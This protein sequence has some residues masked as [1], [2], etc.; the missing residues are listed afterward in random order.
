[1]SAAI[2][3]LIFPTSAFA[4]TPA[5]D[6]TGEWSGF[7]QELNYQDDIYGNYRCN[8]TWKINAQVTQ[9]GNQL[10]IHYYGI[11]TKQDQSHQYYCAQISDH[12]FILTGT[13]DG[14]RITINDFYFPLAGWYASAG[15]K[16][17]GEEKWQDYND[18][19]VLLSGGTKLS[20][21]LS[22]TNFKVVPYDDPEPAPKPAPFDQDSQNQVGS[23][24]TN[25]GSATITTTDG[26][27]VN[28]NQLE[29]GQTIQTGT[30]TNVEILLIDE[31]VVINLKENT[32][33]G[34]YKIIFDPNEKDS[35][36][37][38]G[39]TEGFS[40]GTGLN[41]KH[42]GLIATG[43]ATGILLIITG[44]ATPGVILIGTVF[45]LVTGALVYATSD[46][47]SEKNQKVIFTPDAVLLPHGTKFTVTVENGQTKLDV[48]EGEVTVF[49][50][51]ENDPIQTVKAGNS[52]SIS[53]NDDPKPKE[54]VP[55][56]IKN[57]AKWW[58]EG[59]LDDADFVTV[60]QYMVKEKAIYIPDLP[61]QNIFD[62]SNY[63]PTLQFAKTTAKLW[64]VGEMSEDEFINDSIK[65]LYEYGIISNENF[66]ETTTVDIIKRGTIQISIVKESSIPDIVESYNP[67]S[68]K[69]YSGTTAT[70]TND[71]SA[72]H[73]VTSGTMSD[74][75]VGSMFDSGLIPA[76][77]TW[78]YKFEKS[79]EWDYFCILHPW[80][81]GTVSVN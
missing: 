63:I 78:S 8:T 73:T 29:S 6:L 48:L 79:G 46:S 69:V 36:K 32:K 62:Q 75:I 20:I 23:I 5:A 12:D 9:D 7:G 1:M 31:S 80:M 45:V 24:K 40:D 59:K 13:I 51:N 47:S 50:L 41:A 18:D 76:G 61:K 66:R 16:L 2:V 68:I 42:I 19:G 60:I 71:D 11:V 4:L 49:P 39:T 34:V 54:R 43:F 30:D 27:V 3:S 28:S 26:K 14:S 72:A 22:P 35:Y 25:R 57:I 67:S 38:F 52:I 53:K 44:T 10:T 58:N 56:W 21:Q 64:A 37:L 33:L 70:W 81:E 65:S 55:G 15:I 77:N 74:N 17:E